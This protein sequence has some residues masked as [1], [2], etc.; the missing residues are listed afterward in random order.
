MSWRSAR[1]W[2]R[3]DST[4]RVSSRSNDR[5]HRRRASMTSTR[6]ER[7][8]LCGAV[9]LS[10]NHQLRPRAEKDQA[11]TDKATYNKATYNK[12]TYNKALLRLQ[13][14]L[15]KMQEWVHD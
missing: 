11:M 14:E 1:R 2:S 12:A 7:P 8:T 13:E 5:F 6:R 3:R 10:A 15:V 4:R 9:P